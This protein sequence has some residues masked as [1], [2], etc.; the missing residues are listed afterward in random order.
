MSRSSEWSLINLFP[1]F[2]V[3]VRVSQAVSGLNSGMCYKC[4]ICNIVTNTKVSP[5]HRIS[6]DNWLLIYVHENNTELPFSFRMS[7]CFSAHFNY[8]LPS[9]VG[10][11]PSRPLFCGLCCVNDKWIWI[12]FGP[13]VSYTRTKNW[14]RYR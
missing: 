1:F 10:G 8:V 9:S 4:P 5:F 6:G 11:L 2:F 7:L 3:S 14:I 13:F 12:S